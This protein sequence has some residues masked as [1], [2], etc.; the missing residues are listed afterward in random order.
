MS[1]FEDF[2]KECG[3][4]TNH[5]SLS[6]AQAYSGWKCIF[7]KVRAGS[8]VKLRPG[9][10]QPVVKGILTYGLTDEE[11]FFILSYTATFSSWIN[12][13]LRNRQV[14]TDCQT[15]YATALDSAL[16]KL[17][18][19]NCPYLYRMDSPLCG[20]NEELHWFVKQKGK[21]IRV[22]NFLSVAKSNWENTETTWKIAIKHSESN[23][24]DLDQCRNNPEEDEA[25]Y[26]RNSL[27][28]V[29]DVTG[30]VILLEE[31]DKATEPIIELTGTYVGCS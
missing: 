21:I 18:K 25:V 7:K 4:I 23:A 17:P 19:C 27:F 13:P 28:K 15:Y 3:Q 20:K 2:L 9:L 5:H 16:S 22:P 31:M 11:A 10:S 8:S 30:G 12:F 26:K 1:K 14:L 6:I 24:F 29:L